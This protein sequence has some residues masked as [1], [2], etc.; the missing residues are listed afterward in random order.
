[1]D[2]QSLARLMAVILV[3]VAGTAAAIFVARDGTASVSSTLPSIASEANSPAPLRETL[4]RCVA[5]GEAAVRD[6]DCL[7]AWAESRQRFLSPAE[8]R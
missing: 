2:G 8:G 7:A 4:Q 1:M 6:A 3:A 5:L